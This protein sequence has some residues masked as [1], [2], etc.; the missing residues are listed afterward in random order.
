M[1]DSTLSEPSR[2]PPTEKLGQVRRDFLGPRF[3][4]QTFITSTY[5]RQGGLQQQ[6]TVE[7]PGH[8]ALRPP[9]FFSRAKRDRL[10]SSYRIQGYTDGI[11]AVRP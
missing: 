8:L 11:N 5:T 4:R 9:P 7:A 2:E 1:L 10:Q 3:C 6:D